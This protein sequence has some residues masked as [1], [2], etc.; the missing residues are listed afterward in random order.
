MAPWVSETLKAMGMD[1]G[2]GLPASVVAKAYVKSVAERIT[3]QVID[4]QV[5]EWF[6]RWLSGPSPTGV[7]GGG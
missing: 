3:G 7:T 1:P 2:R 6:Q 5:R 4:A